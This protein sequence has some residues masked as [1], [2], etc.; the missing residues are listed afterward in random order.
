[1]TGYIKGVLPRNVNF[2]LRRQITPTG[3]KYIFKIGLIRKRNSAVKLKYKR[4]AEKLC[5]VK[6]HLH[7]F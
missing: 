7:G 5:I 4:H 6:C 2:R 1:M 3:H